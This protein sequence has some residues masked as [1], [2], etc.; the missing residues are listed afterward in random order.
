MVD[1][2]SGEK[3]TQVRSCLLANSSGGGMLELYECIKPRGRSIP[4]NNYWGDAG[5]LEMCLEAENI[6]DVVDWCRAERV[7][8]LHKPV[9]TAEGGQE[10]WFQYIYDPDGIPVETIASMPIE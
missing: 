5:Y 7:Y 1:E 10:V 9:G 3:G 6:H 2:V 8:Y 4:L